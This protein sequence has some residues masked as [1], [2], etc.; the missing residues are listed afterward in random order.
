MHE[1][2]RKKR[3]HERERFV[4]GVWN[5]STV[6]RPSILVSAPAEI[7][8]KSAL[9]VHDEEVQ[10]KATLSYHVVGLVALEE[11]A[12]F[13][14]AAEYT[15]DGIRHGA[16]PAESGQHRRD[17]VVGV[18]LVRC[19]LVTPEAG[20]RHWYSVHVHA[21]TTTVVIKDRLYC[22]WGFRTPVDVDDL[23][24]RRRTPSLVY[25]EDWGPFRRA[26]RRSVLGEVVQR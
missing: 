5:A 20:H 9:L 22:G 23:R 6:G 15:P 2:T 13:R 11:V 1:V 25:A 18:E 26:G 14:G 3:C 7:L 4:G 16:D 10:G 24:C 19:E 12:P 8:L 17:E 21:F